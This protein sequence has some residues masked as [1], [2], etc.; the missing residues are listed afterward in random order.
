MRE[1]GKRGTEGGYNLIEVMIAMGLLGTV[2]IT[3]MTLFV[4]GRKNVYSGKEM[5]AAVSMSTRVSEDLSG[6]TVD[7]IYTSFGI[8]GTSTTALSGSAFNVTVD[9][10]GRKATL[11]ANTYTGSFIRRTTDTLV[12][13]A[14]GN[15]T[16]G[17]LTR[18]KN[19]MDQNLRFADGAVNVVIT[20]RNPDP[21]LT[22]GS[23]TTLSVSTASVVRIRVLVR[24]ME[25]S[26][27]RQM[28]IDTVKT[29]RPL[30]VD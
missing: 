26:R 5:T 4:M 12:T 13:T 30:P 11:P 9:S 8:S 19:E 18:W 7:E 10:T 3:I 23:P 28:I 2:L 29:K 27:P 24:W 16:G 1:H 25:E 14:G 15:D 22:G 17:F 20:P 6:L 21:P